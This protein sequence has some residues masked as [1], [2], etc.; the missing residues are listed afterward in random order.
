MMVEIAIWDTHVTRVD[1]ASESPICIPA[2]VID[3][4]SFRRWLHTS[5]FP[6]KG[7]VF[8]IN[9]EIWVDTSGEEFFEHGQV[10]VE[11]ATV[12]YFLVNRMD[13]GYFAPEGTRFSNLEAEISTEPDGMIISKEALD[14][15][16]VK[17]ISGEKGK[18]TEVIGS[19]EIVIE[20]VSR[21][22]VEKDYESLKTGYYE[23]GVQ[24]YWLVDARDEK[25]LTFDLFRRG[26][27]EFTPARKVQ[28]W[29][30]SNVL[31]KSFRL[32]RTKDSSGRPKFN[33]K[34]R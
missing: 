29:V 7:K 30:K 25:H 16:R 26:K 2:W 22:S 11:I 13:F 20:V 15:G 34:V 6:E 21:T 33:L 18:N 28:G 17:F 24:E 23:A 8:F 14:S 9:H 10:K 3:F 27:D 12:L 32:A 31:G 1:F 4:A 5:E 19:P